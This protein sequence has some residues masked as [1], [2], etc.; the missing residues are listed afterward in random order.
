MFRNASATP[1]ELLS[2]VKMID[3]FKQAAPHWN[4]LPITPE[5]SVKYI[6]KLIETASAKDNG[7][8]VSHLGNK[9]WL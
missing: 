7:A 5:V 1:E 9:Q 4:G 6:L 2:V 8:F 3:M